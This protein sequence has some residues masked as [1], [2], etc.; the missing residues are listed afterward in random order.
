MATVDPRATLRRLR[1]SQTKAASL[2][3]VSWRTVASWLAPDASPWHR[4]LSGP[5][6]RLLW[7]LERHPELVDELRQAE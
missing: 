2:L 5:A 4:P 7:L 3:G 1:L 6:Y